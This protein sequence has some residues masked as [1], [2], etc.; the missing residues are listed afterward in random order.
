MQENERIICQN[1][2]ISEGVMY[3]FIK[4]VVGGKQGDHA[5]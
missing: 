1:I 4:K 5:G 3:E 2:R